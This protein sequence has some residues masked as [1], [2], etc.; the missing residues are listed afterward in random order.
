[1]NEPGS[2]E[3]WPAPAKLNLFLQITGRRA[4]GY[5]ELQTVFQFIDFSDDFVIKSKKGFLDFIHSFGRGQLPYYDTWSFEILALFYAEFTS[6]NDVN[7]TKNGNMINDYFDDIQNN[8]GIDL[9]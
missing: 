4:D 3:F 6:R 2:G 5:H 9:D 1:M 7:T 8:R